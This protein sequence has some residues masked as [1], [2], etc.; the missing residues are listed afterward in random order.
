MNT[1]NPRR[2]ASGC[3]DLTAYT[4][5]KNVGKGSRKCKNATNRLTKRKDY[6]R[7]FICSPFRGDIVY[8]REAAA[9]YARYALD[10]NCFPI[11]PHLYLPVFMNDN[12][13]AERELAIRFGLRLLGGCKELWM[14][15]DTV[16]SGMRREL[17]EAHRKRIRIRYFTTECNEVSAL[18]KN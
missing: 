11:A 5:L 15:G 12:D 1:N 8:N 3:T 10:H 14:F 16:S 7:V 13:P 17:H 6:P 2:N 9:K 18:A 4:A